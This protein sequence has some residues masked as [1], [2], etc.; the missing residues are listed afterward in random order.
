MQNNILDYL[1]KINDRFPDKVVYKDETNDIT[2][3]R[4]R[5]QAMK[6][7]SFLAKRVKK[8]SPVVIISDKNINT[9]I[10]YLGVL[11]S[12]C[13]YVPVG[14]DLP[15]FRMNLILNLVQADLVLVD[16]EYE[17]MVK[18]LD[19]SGTVFSLDD[20]LQCPVE[21]TLLDRRRAQCLDTDPAYVIFT[22]G[23]TGKPKGVIES[24]RAVIDY[25]DVFAD[26]FHIGSDEIFGNQ[27][28][29]DYIAAIRDLYLPLKTGASTVLI[30]KKYFS[31]PGRLF[32]YLNDNKVTTICW[33]VSAFCLCNDL[34]AFEH[35]PLQTVRNVFFT[36][37]VM[38][39]RHL[40]LWQQQ[41][42]E[43]RFINHYGPTE[44]TASC[45]WYIVEKTVSNEDVLP[46]GIPFDN[47]EILLLNE[48]DREVKEPGMKGEICVRGSSLALGYY[49]DFEKTEQ[50][51]IDSPL[52]NIYRERI[53]KTGDIGSWDEQ[54]I[55]WFH[56]RKDSQI[57]HA[58]HR[59]EL[60]EIE[61]T[62]RMLESVSECCCLY[63]QEKE[64]LWLFYTGRDAEKKELALFMRQRLPGFM[65]PRKFV[66][67]EEL[68]KQFNGKADLEKLRTMMR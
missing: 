54:G 26:T 33:V 42:P 45:T 15:E 41:L 38:P 66:K 23:S 3:S 18:K 9:P 2:F 11:Y 7:G 51:F 52:N 44:I 29:L 49:R 61:G 30:A 46:I 17:E 12:G 59:I 22:S 13:F 14:V 40:R 67:L 57:K 47:T 35:A 32:D 58:G 19:I 65:I 39:C 20:A 36:G 27:A 62:A 16:P 4:L 55:L 50:A 64:Q 34:N 10:M 31:I 60:S 63:S 56:G 25:I 28:P 43:A 6:V 48:D 5:E 68:P 53:Y 37:A 24:H 8:N 21:D 1:E